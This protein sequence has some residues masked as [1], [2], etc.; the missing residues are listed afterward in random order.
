MCVFGDDHVTCYMRAEVDASE[1]VDAQTQSGV[2]YGSFYANF[3][4]EF[5]RLFCNGYYEQFMIV[6]FEYHLGFGFYILAR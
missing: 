2:S 3:L 1:R 4:H 6:I 5:Y